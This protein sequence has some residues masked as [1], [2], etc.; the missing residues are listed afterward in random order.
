MRH[1]VPIPRFEIVTTPAD[2]R[3]AAE[4]IGRMVVVKAQVHVG[5]RGKAGGVKLAKTADEAEAHASNILGMDIK[6][7]T[8]EKIMISDAVDID[9][10]YYIGMIVDRQ[11]KKPVYMVSEAGGIDIEQVANETPEKIHKLAINP[12]K[13]LSAADASTLAAKI[14]SRPEVAAKVAEFITKLY[15]GFIGSDAS[16]AEI[17][18]LVVTPDG[19]VWAVDAKMN[20]DD[21]A[22]YR[23]PDIAEMRDPAGETDEVRKA[24]EM[25]LSY[26]KLD[27]NV[28]CLV[29][30]AGLAMTTMDVIQHYGGAPANFLDIGGSSSPDKVVTAL[31]IITSDPNVRSILI[32]I[33]GGITRCDDVARGLVQALE[34]TS[35]EIPIV[36]RLT[37]TNEDEARKILAKHQFVSAT[38]MDEAV[39]KAVELAKQP[40]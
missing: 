38:T 4:D 28:G 7:L 27:G 10:E 26:V 12:V 18:P 5:G 6:G 1:G 20:I 31:E 39:E 25:G 29:N 11:T 19:E 40:A 33:F 37:G 2:A 35:I 24:R 3:K 34:Q 23:H 9:R 32:N 8:V 14:E 30:G 16:L 17:N 36:V 15:D 21:N 22:L 13:G